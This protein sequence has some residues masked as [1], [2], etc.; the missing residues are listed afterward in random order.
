MI[1]NGFKI[2]G[3]SGNSFFFGVKSGSRLRVHVMNMHILGSRNFNLM[4]KVVR[5]SSYGI[6]LI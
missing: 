6:N 4:N 1:H 3:L 5:I 2:S